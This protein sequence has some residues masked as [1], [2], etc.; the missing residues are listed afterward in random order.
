MKGAN[1]FVMQQLA[2]ATNVTVSIEV[3]HLPDAILASPDEN[4]QIAALL[5]MGYDCVIT[6]AVLTPEKIPYMVRKDMVAAPRQPGREVPCRR[7]AAVQQSWL[8][9]APAG[10]PQKRR[11]SPLPSSPRASSS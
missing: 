4:V 7:V 3:V 9:H 6:P 2:Q 1:V 11:A 8:T 10:L 5:A